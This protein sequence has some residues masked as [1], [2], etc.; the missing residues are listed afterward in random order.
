M[1]QD[2]TNLPKSESVSFL[3]PKPELNDLQ[4]AEATGIDFSQVASAPELTEKT[5]ITAS[6]DEG[7]KVFVGKSDAN[8]IR[9]FP[10]SHQVRI[11][12]V[13]KSTLVLILVFVLLFGAVGYLGWKYYYEGPEFLA[14]MFSGGGVGS[15]GSDA[16]T[17]RFH[18]ER[19]MDNNELIALGNPNSGKETINLIY[20]EGK[21][22][23]I[24]KT[25]SLI[26]AN[27]SAA[28]T[29]KNNIQND[30]QRTVETLS[31]NKKDPFTTKI[32]HKDGH[33]SVSHTAAAAQINP[34]RAEFFSM[35]VEDGKVVT[36]FTKIRRNYGKPTGKYSCMRSGARI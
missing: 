20:K 35:P 15:D 27:P 10:N 31:N 26:Y 8:K 5:E 9:A 34:K 11:W 29:S 25:W 3:D 12:R 24:S 14:M 36:D 6:L 18:C 1:E 4:Q 2:E 17:T 33:V 7:N 23:E 32:E 21:F 22:T 16:K 28:H 19:S 30:Y 13:K